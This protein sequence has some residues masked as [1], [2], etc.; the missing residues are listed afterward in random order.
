MH[1]P[2]FSAAVKSLLLG[3]RDLLKIMTKCVWCQLKSATSKDNAAMMAVAFSDTSNA[4]DGGE[5]DH[6]DPEN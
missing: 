4:P 2:Y 5:A 6:A 3:K 1:V